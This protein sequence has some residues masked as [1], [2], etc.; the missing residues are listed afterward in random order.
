MVKE[1]LK[2]LSFIIVQDAVNYASWENNKIKA[3][4]LKEQ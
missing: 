2:T 4:Q 1:N 3:I